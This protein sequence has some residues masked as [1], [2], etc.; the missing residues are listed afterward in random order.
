VHPALVRVT[1]TFS[2]RV[3]DREGAYANNGN[4]YTYRF[5][6]SGFGVHPDGYL[7]TVAHCVDPNDL[8]V[9][10]TFIRAAA[11]ESAANRPDIP[12][13]KWLE[14]GRSAWSIEGPAAGSSIV[15]EIRVSGVVSAPPEGMRARVVD[16][17]PTGQGDVALL[18][19]DTTNLPALELAT[20][21]AMAVGTPLLAAGYPEES[22]GDFIEPGASPSVH[23]AAVIDTK[24][25]GGQPVYQIS[26]G[27]KEGMSGGPVVDHNGRVLGINSARGSATKP[28]DIAIPIGTFSDLLGRNGARAELGPPELA[29]RDA[30]D[31]YYAGE[32]TD[33]IEAID[34]LQQ[35]GPTHPRIGE[36]RTDAEASRDLHGD[37]S[38]NQ[39]T[40][41]LI[42][43]GVAGAPC[44]LRSAWCW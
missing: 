20:G 3:H 17:R 7:A 32:Y 2:A 30:L 25:D 4:P 15:S 5:T 21:S 24:T 39:L 35:G 14:F 26:A 38:E 1:G 43:V 10:E 11:E 34:R 29:Y 44:W 23:E 36:L 27:L 42:W 13:E 9:R 18:K 8:T 16:A 19:V 28:L 41:I 6:C 33:A 37:A 22:M 40:Q 12:L 31:A